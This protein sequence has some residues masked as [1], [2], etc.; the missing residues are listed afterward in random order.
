MLQRNATNSG[1]TPIVETPSIWETTASALR[2]LIDRNTPG[3]PERQAVARELRSLHHHLRQTTPGYQGALEDALAPE[4]RPPAVG[5]SWK[6]LADNPAVRGGLLGIYAGR[7][8]PAHDHPGSRGALLVLTG[9]L[10]VT[11]FAI[12]RQM[13]GDLTELRRVAQQDCR[14]GETALIDAGERNIHHV[15]ALTERCFTLNLLLSPFAEP[16]RSWYLPIIDTEPDVM[17]VR[18]LPRKAPLRA[19]VQ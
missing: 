1:A 8:I 14:A 15:V 4:S 17:I 19:T 18:R 12:Q 9:K 5:W 6:V 7:P 13:P 10:R 11:W 16:E 2:A 3:E